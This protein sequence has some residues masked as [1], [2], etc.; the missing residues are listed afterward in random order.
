M[1]RLKDI[2]TSNLVN[3]DSCFNSKMVRLKVVGKRGKKRYV[4]MF[5]FQNGTIKSSN[6]FFHLFV[7]ELFQFQNGTI[8]RMSPSVFA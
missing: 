5:Q 1:V 7:F 2:S 4:L 6:N 3:Y 8:K